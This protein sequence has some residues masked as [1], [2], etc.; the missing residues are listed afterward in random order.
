MT[1]ARSHI[2]TALPGLNQSHVPQA[3]TSPMPDRVSVVEGIAAYEVA[4]PVVRTVCE[5]RGSELAQPEAR[6]WL[7]R[8]TSAS[9]ADGAAWAGPATRG[10]RS[11]R[12]R[13]RGSQVSRHAAQTAGPLSASVRKAL[14]LSEDGNPKALTREGE[15][16]HILLHFARI[17]V[18]FGTFFPA[19]RLGENHPYEDD[20][21]PDDLHRGELLAEPDPGHDRREDRLEHGND[22]HARRGNVV[23][24]AHEEDE[25][26]HGPQHDDVG[27]QQPRV[28]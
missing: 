28:P 12:Q 19:R 11:R 14:G 17:L 22:G 3:M 21:A 27:K 15:D 7:I 2:R 20:Q 26:H 4:R 25:G 9:M 5:P 16:C 18:R 8:S 1:G 6:A 13:E 24:R 10:R 23:E